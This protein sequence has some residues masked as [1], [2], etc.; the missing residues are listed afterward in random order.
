MVL[1][2]EQTCLSRVSSTGVV[3]LTVEPHLG[4]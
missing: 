3:K 2:P 4:Q 1:H